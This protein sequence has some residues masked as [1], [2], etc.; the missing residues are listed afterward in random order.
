MD[1][2]IPVDHKRKIKEIGKRKKYLHFTRELKKLSIE[3]MRAIP[4]V[5]G[6]LGKGTGRVGN[7]RTNRNHQEYSILNN[8]QNTEESSVKLRKFVVT[9]TM[10]K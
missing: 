8:G 10:V 1:F 6:A 2:A 5:F 4:V 9:H 3:E 7:R